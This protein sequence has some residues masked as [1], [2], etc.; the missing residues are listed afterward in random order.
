MAEDA[1]RAGKRLGLKITVWTM[2]VTFGGGVL[3]FAYFY[4]YLNDAY[5]IITPD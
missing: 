5:R 2:L 1:Q 4:S 3:A